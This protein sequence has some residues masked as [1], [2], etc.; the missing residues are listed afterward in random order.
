MFK[1]TL[2]FVVVELLCYRREYIYN[3]RTCSLSFS[4]CIPK[5]KMYY[6]SL[7]L[8]CVFGSRTLK[9]RKSRKTSVGTW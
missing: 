5:S 1:E 4:E 8:T 9:S 2:Y 3:M 6:E 7:K